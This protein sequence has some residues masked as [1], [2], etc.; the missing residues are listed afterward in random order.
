MQFTSNELYMLINLHP[1]DRPFWLHRTN[2]EEA[3]LKGTDL[4][5]ADLSA[6]NLSG[7]CL[8]W[9]DLSGPT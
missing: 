2:L 9:A 5:G 4:S 7:A 1:S 6:A 8:R 3:H